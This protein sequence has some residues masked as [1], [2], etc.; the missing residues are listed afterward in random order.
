M[1]WC[2]R[3]IDGHIPSTNEFLPRNRQRTI[4]QWYRDLLQRARDHHRGGEAPDFQFA[5]KPRKEDSAVPQQILD[6]LSNNADTL[7]LAEQDIYLDW[8]STDSEHSNI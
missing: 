3:A 5:P 1:L 6:E 7:G 8:K 4:P 2:E